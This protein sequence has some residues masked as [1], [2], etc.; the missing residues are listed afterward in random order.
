MNIDYRLTH[1][2]AEPPH[3][4]YPTDAGADLHAH[5]AIP[6]AL[7]PGERA[8]VPTGVALAIPPGYVGL[9][10]PRS[11]LAA[12]HGITV[13]NAPGTVDAA[14]RGEIKGCLINHGQEPH[15]IN[16]GDRIAQLLIQKVELPNFAEADTL[17]TTTRGDGGF[18][19][20]G[21]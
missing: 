14:Y 13:L 1:P 18:G 15:T 8:L 21:A 4:A 5:I 20:T 16:P 12:K 7:K 3:R 19:S 6:V 9:V 2:G 10:H 11:G 17:D